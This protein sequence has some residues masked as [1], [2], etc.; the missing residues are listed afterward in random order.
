[1]ICSRDRLRRLAWLIGLCQHDNQHR[2][3]KRRHVHQLLGCT[4]ARKA[5]AGSVPHGRPANGA[6]GASPSASLADIRIVCCGSR[7]RAQ[8]SAPC[9]RSAGAIRQSPRAMPAAAPRPECNDRSAPVALALTR[10]A[11]NC[12]GSCGPRRI[13]RRPREA[14][15]GLGGTR[16]VEHSMVVSAERYADDGLADRPGSRCRRQTQTAHAPPNPMANKEGWPGRLPIHACQRG[17]YATMGVQAPKTQRERR[18]RSAV[19]PARAGGE[20]GSMTGPNHRLDATWR[21]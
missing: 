21:T 7:R 8:P 20:I 19:C 9:R 3:L 5:A 2:P 16:R 15:A 17:G 18:T 1:M 14:P 6:P 4:V 12:A 13:H 10:R 11:A